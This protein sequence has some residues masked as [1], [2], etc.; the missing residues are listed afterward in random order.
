MSWRW[1]K[2]GL[3]IKRWVLILCCGIILVVLGAI[4]LGLALFN[5]HGMDSGGIR[6]NLYGIG[7]TFIACGAVAVFTAVYRLVRNVEKLLRRSDE[8]RGLTDLAWT[9]VQREAGARVVCLGG[10]TGLSTLLYGLKTHPVDITA[11]VSVADDG[12]SSGR[13]RKDFDILP[14][15]DIRNCVVA[16]ADAGPR[17]RELMQYRFAEGEFEGHSFGN[18][19]IMVLA[20]IC[21]DFG[22]AVMEINSLLSVRGRV[23]PVSLERVSLVA[24]HP[25]GSKTTGQRSIATCGKPIER[26]EQ[27]PPNGR[28]PRD[29][30]GAIE[31]ADLI[32]LG[33]GSLYT[34]VLP[35]LLEPEVAAAVARSSAV[36]I[37]LVN[38][39]TQPGETDGFTVSRHYEVLRAHAPDV[40][41]DALLVNSY[42]PTDAQLAAVAESGIALTAFDREAMSGYTVPVY[43]RDV[44][45]REHPMRHDPEKLG[46]AVM[47]IYRQIRG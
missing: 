4:I 30:L 40:V 25:D 18:L 1:L 9:R 41:P 36:K 21:G 46:R 34:S 10:G 39:M 37:F 8:T 20:Q 26:L 28:P 31:A 47:E 2:P 24:T 29:V 16:L 12:G 44:I 3:R 23:L 15:G 11:V 32:V 35:N 38:T 42:R 45:D 14:P 33:P 6:P 19:F 22:T 17:M 5:P 43:L 27:K 13:L 7:I